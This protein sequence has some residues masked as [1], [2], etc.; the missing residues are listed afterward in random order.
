MNF[1]ERI[2]WNRLLLCRI[3]ITN[4]A[5]FDHFFW[6]DIAICVHI[7]RC[8][9]SSNYRI[10]RVDISHCLR[11]VCKGTTRGTLNFFECVTWDRLLL[12]RIGITDI[13]WL[14][15][16][17]RDDITISIRILDRYVAT[18]Y[19]LNWIFGVD[20]DHCL[21]LVCKST[22]CGALNFFECVTWNRL[23]F[24]RIGVTYIAWFD[25]I[26]WNDVTIC[27]HVLHCYTATSYWIFRVDISH[28]L[29]LVCK[30]T[31][32]WALDFFERVTWDRFL[33]GRIGITDIPRLDHI[34][35][36]DIAICVHVLHCYVATSYRLNWIFCVD[37]LHCLRLICKGTTHWALNFFECISWD[38]FLFCLIGVTDTPWL[39]HIIWNGVTI[40]VHILGR[41]IATGYWIFRIDISHCLSL[42]CKG[43]TCGALNFFECVTWDR[44]LFCRISVTNIPW[45][46]HIIWNDITICVHVLRCYICINNYSQNF[47]VV[48]CH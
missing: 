36:Y 6:N 9:I 27:V 48:K 17:I 5:W 33:F 43:T 21:R 24:G 1:F 47:S 13:S 8:Y 11:L 10:L 35:R 14:D 16:I 44:F 34:I 45:L 20:I 42:V 31:C 4:I 32:C 39:D 3:S 23:L 19:G 29:R 38:W 26:I 2:P 28:C 7:P 18:R 15:H 25:H 41:Y 30:G 37:I 12:C 46:D 40:G 22:T